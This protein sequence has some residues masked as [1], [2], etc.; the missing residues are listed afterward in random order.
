M[1]RLLFLTVALLWAMCALAQSD[2][3]K[4]VAAAAG[5][6]DTGAAVTQT[7]AASP[8]PASPVATTSILPTPAEL[9]AAKRES[10]RSDLLSISSAI[11]MALIFLGGLVVAGV[12]LLTPA[13]QDFSFRLHWGGFGGGSTG[14]R[15]SPPLVGFITGLAMVALGVTLLFGILQLDTR[16]SPQSVRQETKEEVDK[17]A[18]KQAAV[19]AGA[20][21]AAAA[22][23]AAAEE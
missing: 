13:T 18:V 6:P 12:A 16:P 23:A 15:M 9:A 21:R 11:A 4:P 1:A 8:P 7:P 10:V 19:E 5:A 20:A 22:A 2:A 17:E 3:A 14:W